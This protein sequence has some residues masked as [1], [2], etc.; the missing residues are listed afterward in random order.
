MCLLCSNDDGDSVEKQIAAASLE[1]AQVD[2][3]PWGVRVKRAGSLPGSGTWTHQYG[4]I[5][6]TIKSEDKRVKLPLGVLWYGGVSHE[7][8]LPRHGHGP[9]EQ[10]VGGRL[11]I[12]GINTLTARDVYTGRVLWQREFKDLGTHD[13]Y[14]DDTYKETPLDPAY[15]QVH[16]PGANGRGTNYVVTEDRVYILEGP[17]CHVLDTASGEDLMDIQ[18]PQVD[19]D[20]P[21]EWGYIGVYKDVLL[22]GVGFAQYRKRHGLEEPADAPTGNKAGFGPKSLD[23]AASMAIVGFD[24]HTGKQL[25]EVKANHSFWHNGIVAGNDRVFVIDRNPK[26]V[27]E[28]LRRRGK[29]N[30][31]PIAC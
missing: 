7:D 24:R 10:V 25:W 19:A 5:A 29:S 11:F 21:N 6:N 8:V 30:P 4:N 13:V 3:Q 12:E 23:R 31:E 15:N 28:F 22:G 16:I 1:N 9:P 20:R 18:L 14:F 26:P 27:E 17:V 2:R